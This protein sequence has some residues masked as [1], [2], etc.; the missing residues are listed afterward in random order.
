MVVE[1]GG[2]GGG[3]GGGTITATQSP[4]PWVA[5][6]TGDLNFHTSS[7]NVGIALIYNLP[8]CVTDTVEPAGQTDG[9]GNT[10]I[11]FQLQSCLQTGSGSVT[12]F[13]DFG[14]TTVTSGIT[15]ACQS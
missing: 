4:N 13:A 7:P 12:I 8:G 6:Q 11:P 1:A 14:G 15:V 2:G 9:N 5:G 10:T 3:G